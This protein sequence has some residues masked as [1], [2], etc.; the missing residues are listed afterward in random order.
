MDELVKTK[1]A[2]L[3]IK[4]IVEQEPEDNSK[5]LVLDIIKQATLS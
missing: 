5:K 3:E 1:Q 2:L 4:K